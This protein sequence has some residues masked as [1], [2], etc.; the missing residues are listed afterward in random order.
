MTMRSA[1]ELKMES[2]MF[3][4]S[5]RIRCLMLAALIAIAGLWVAAV[6]PQIRGLVVLVFYTIPSHMF[7][8]PFPH[9]PAL[10]YYA[11]NFSPLAVTIS[12]TVG[13]LLAGVFDYWL[14]LSIAHHPKFRPKY[15]GMKLYQKSVAFFQKAPFWTLVITGYSTIPDYPFTFLSMASGHPLWKY[16]IALLAGRAPR[17]YTY[18]ALG[19][20]LQPPTWMLIVLAILPVAAH[21]IKKLAAHLRAKISINRERSKRQAIRFSIPLTAVKLREALCNSDM[22]V[23]RC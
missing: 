2:A 3:S 9:E 22:S 14:F 4:S 8:S 6:F 5:N 13:C 20:A 16:E 10:L 11:K 18:A 7:I 12:A 19:H 15:A 17:Y 21:F 1:V 23:L